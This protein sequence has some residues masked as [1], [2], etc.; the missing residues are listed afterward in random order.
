MKKASSQNKRFLNKELFVWSELKFVKRWQKLK[1]W[2]KGIGRGVIIA[3][4]LGLGTW[5][6]IFPPGIF[7]SF[8]LIWLPV[9]GEEV[10][11]EPIAFYTSLVLWP[12]SL[13]IFGYLKDRIQKKAALVVFYVFISLLYLGYFVLQFF[14]YAVYWD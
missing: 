9:F 2:Q 11:L 13:G 10:I 6:G 3:I 1:G 5:T 4:A 7:L 12:T 14:W 8:S